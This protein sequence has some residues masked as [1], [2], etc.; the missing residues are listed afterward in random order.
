MRHRNISFAT[1]AGIRDLL[2]SGAV[3]DVRGHRVRELRNRMTV[4]ERPRERCLFVP[5]RGNNMIAAVA[6][7]LWVIAGRDDIA[8]L[9]SYLPRARDFSDD[10][11]TWR[12]AYGP[13]LR[14]WNGVDQLAE[15]RRLLLEEPA[16]R[17]A[18]ISLFDPDRDFVQSRDI[19]CNNW[20]HWL[21]RDGKLNLTI[22]MRS[23]DVVWG[24][25]GVDSFEW[26]VLQE[27]MA[28]WVG[29]E[30]GD[31]TYL[32]TSFHLYERHDR[33]ARRMAGSFG[34][35][36]CY[37]YGLDA[38]AFTTAFDH[39]DAALS[40]WFA[41]E[42]EVRA[43]PDSV[44]DADRR[45]GDRFL[46]LALEMVRLHHGVEHGWRA[47]RL[48]EGLARLPVCD[49]T[50][51]AYELYG[52][53]FPGVLDSI[54]NPQIASF[55]SAYKGQTSGRTGAIA[56]LIDAIKNLH[57][58]K[59]AAY[60]AAWKKRGELTSIL[61]NVARKVDRL[62][63]HRAT[64]TELDDES[65]LDTA[66]DLFVYLI[67]YRLFLLESAPDAAPKH[68]AHL[69]RPF[70]NSRHAFDLSA[71]QYRDHEALS[72]PADAIICDIV[73]NFEHL[74]TMAA[75]GAAS[76]T[77]R[78]ASASALADLAFGLVMLL[79]R[80]HPHLVRTMALTSGTAE[81]APG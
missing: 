40:E 77:E 25:S 21:I 81:P 42:D 71:D 39:I 6:E 26:S 78:L 4:L 8:W 68:L 17:R 16:T 75:T 31:A 1:A 32:A 72:Q 27:M 61:C 74:H 14:K 30:M 63:W 54:R 64:G 13:R 28:F 12:G 79:G 3:V 18:A 47:E 38:P 34:G 65:V 35:V 20:L 29:A 55:I 59:D 5:H 80:N 36:T 37:D 24:F 52:R 19:P 45:L 66:V 76:V 67:K 49:F 73:M 62:E 41:L 22:G 58:R 2:R 60:G 69:L 7:T 57:A 9:L 50:A 46:A 33:R 11:L 53:R 70:S 15:T 23:N 48:G 43:D 51:A 10:G 44:P 56:G